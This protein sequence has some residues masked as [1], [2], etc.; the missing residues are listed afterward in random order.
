M[1]IGSSSSVV[2]RSYARPWMLA[3]SFVVLFVLWLMAASWGDDLIREL[4]K[5]SASVRMYRDSP[6]LILGLGFVVC[7]ICLVLSYLLLVSRPTAF[8]AVWLV[9]LALGDARLGVFQQGSL[10][11]R[12]TMMLVLV[13]LGVGSLFRRTV[14]TSSDWLPRLFISYTGLQLL[15]VIFNGPSM[16]ALSM[17]PMQLALSVGVVFG[18][19]EIL[20]TDDSLVHLGRALT[21]AGVLI[22]LVECSSLVASQQPFLGGRFRSWHSLPTGF[23][24]GYV[25]FLVPVVWTA[26]SGGDRVLRMFSAITVCVGAT[27][28]ILSGTRNALLC[29][30]ICIFVMLVVWKRRWIIPFIVVSIVVVLVSIVGD[31]VGGFFGGA[32]E[33][34]VS[35]EETRL[36]VW[37]S[38]WNAVQGQPLWGYGL[39]PDIKLFDVSRNEMQVLDAHNAYLGTWLRLGVG[40][41]FLVVAINILAMMQVVKAWP[42]LFVWRDGKNALILF[43][44]LLLIVVVGGGFEDNLAG[45]GNIQ[46]A[47]WA[48][49]IAGISM[50]GNRSSHRR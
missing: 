11:L 1:R 39:V 41:V 12:Y 21:I 28:I 24:T 13:V 37:K 9:S 6:G 16:E 31:G 32:G 10:L 35:T 33:R 3:V 23:A 19:R 15:H 47:M 7:V 8:M 14:R 46:Q 36:W 43:V 27:L 2:H 30:V 48:L 50:I 4:S 34:I 20:E 38:A 29:L 45:K 44:C 17:L 42:R 26:L 18:F 5:H 25:C 22:T 49:S 40:G